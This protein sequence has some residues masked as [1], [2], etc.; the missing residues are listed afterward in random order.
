MSLV[1]EHLS[2]LRNGKEILSDISF[3]C[4]PGEL[5]VIRGKNGAGKSSLFSALMALSGVEIVSGDFKI[6]DVSY[7][8]HKTY[9]IARAGLFLAHQE[10]PAIDGVSLGVVARAALETM[11]GVTEVPRHSVAFVKPSPN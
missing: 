8:S 7:R 5:V 6:D 4:A 2:I 11:C 3:V 1:V 10:P 9:E